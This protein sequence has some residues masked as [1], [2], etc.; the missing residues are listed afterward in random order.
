M[1]RHLFSYEAGCACDENF[2]SVL[3]HSVTLFKV[4]LL[5]SRHHHCLAMFIHRAYIIPAWKIY[6]TH[7]LT[8]STGEA[9]VQGRR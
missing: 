3:W 5:Q 7:T 9:V 6:S 8:Y 1:A 2:W 4:N